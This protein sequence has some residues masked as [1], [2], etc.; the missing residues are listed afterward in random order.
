[1][2]TPLT[3]E[4]LYQDI[5]DALPIAILVLDGHL[6]VLMANKGISS[7]LQLL[8][9]LASRP[10]HDRH[11][12]ACVLGGHRQPLGRCLALEAA[13]GRQALRATDVPVS[14]PG[15]LAPA[16]L[17]RVEPALHRPTGC[18]AYEALRQGGRQA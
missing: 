6:N 2:S 15:S 3:R 18:T 5:L 7:R 12:V 16:V 8:S 4:Q 1:M 11:A 10:A 14:T 9:F 13:K 17:A